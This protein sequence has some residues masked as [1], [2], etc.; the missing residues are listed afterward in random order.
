MQTCGMGHASGT[1]TF[2][3]GGRD[4]A[5]QSRALKYLDSIWDTIS[6]C[7]DVHHDL[8]YEGR[9]HPLGKHSKDFDRINENVDFGFGR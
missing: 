5:I 8:V 9:E 1:C 6:I 3:Y 4:K 2:E 7:L